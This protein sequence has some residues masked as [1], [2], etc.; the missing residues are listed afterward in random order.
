MAWEMRLGEC[1][2]GVRGEGGGWAEVGRVCV[3][4]MV[5]WGEGRS[6]GG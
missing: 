1:V 3:W 6:G 4:E 2:N 5:R